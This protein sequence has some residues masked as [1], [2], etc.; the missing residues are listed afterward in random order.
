MSSRDL[1]KLDENNPLEQA[2]K[3]NEVKQNPPEPDFMKI[4]V[5][6][7]KDEQGNDVVVSRSE[8][9]DGEKKEFH[10]Q[11]ILEFS[12]Y[13]GFMANIAKCPM[14]VGPMLLDQSQNVVYEEKKAF[15]PEKPHSEFNW[16]WLVFIGLIALP[17]VFV[18]FAFI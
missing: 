13:I 6:H 4:E 3:F 1:R 18:I 14:N 10:H 2:M 7:E 17:V 11:P 9:L 8:Q 15:K 5:F 16:W 12:P